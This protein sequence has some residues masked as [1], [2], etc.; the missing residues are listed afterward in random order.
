MK[1][2]RLFMKTA[3]E[4]GK[5]PVKT[6][7]YKIADTVVEIRS[8]Y[9]MVQELCVDYRWEERAEL[10]IEIC[11]GDIDF[12]REKSAREDAFEGIPTRHFSDAYLETLAVYRKLVTALLD[13]NI[14]L[15]HGSALAVDGEAYIFTAKSGTGKSTHARLW[16]ETFG[17]RVTMVNDDKPLIRV[18]NG[19]AVVYGTPWDGKHRLSTNISLPVKAIC[20]LERSETNQI[21]PITGM[22]GLTMLFQQ[23]YRPEEEASMQKT[24]ELIS[25]MSMAVKLYRLGCNMEPEAATVS[26]E[27]MQ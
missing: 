25:E 12:E 8:L 24:M 16:R 21:S 5:E 11:Q 20:I 9:S 6:G 26:Y 4:E 14:L 27:G 13:R 2:Y 10:V 7:I 17:D 19:Q 18:E 3:A 1:V 15:F 22:Q 23:T